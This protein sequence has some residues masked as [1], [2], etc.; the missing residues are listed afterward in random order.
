MKYY[1][2]EST[3]WNINMSCAPPKEKPV[4]KYFT[5]ESLERDHKTHLPSCVTSTLSKWWLTLLKNP[6][7]QSCANRLPLHVYSW[8]M[9]FRKTECCSC[10]LKGRVWGGRRT[11]RIKSA[12]RNLRPGDRLARNKQKANRADSKISPKTK[13]KY[14][15]KDGKGSEIRSENRWEDKQTKIEIRCPSRESRT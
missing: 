11:R 12:P 7:W 10:W 15:E 8:C 3:V 13:R 4:K 14:Q 2:L 1:Y 6:K 5:P 9:T